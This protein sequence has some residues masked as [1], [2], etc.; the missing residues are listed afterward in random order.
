MGWEVGPGGV[1]VPLPKVWSSAVGKRTRGHLEGE[2]R[3]C[4]GGSVAPS[5]APACG[6][7]VE[8]A[9]GCVFFVGD[10]VFFAFSGGRGWGVLFF[11]C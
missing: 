10:R 6:S 9:V 1:I 3:V 4:E 2:V 7:R 11:L 8:E 5:T